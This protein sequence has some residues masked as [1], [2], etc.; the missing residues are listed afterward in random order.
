MSGIMD[1]FSP[2]KPK[3]EAPTTAPTADD[4]EIQTAR[5]RRAALARQSSGVVATATS[6]PGQRETLG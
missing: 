4:R 1:L 5:R 6:R 2:K 3:V